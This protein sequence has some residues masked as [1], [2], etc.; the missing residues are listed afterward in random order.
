M[1][2]WIWTATLTMAAPAPND[3][4]PPPKQSTV[5]SVYDGDTVTLA[6]GD[7]IRLRWINTPEL[8]PPE[9]YGIEARS[10][11]EGFVKGE[12]VRL[13]MDGENPRD[14]YG[15][16]LAGLETDRGN[17]TIHLL[18]LGLGHV[19]VI[20]PDD[21]DLAPLLAAQKQA[22]E[23]RRGIWTTDRYQGTLH[24]TSFHANAA[25]DD[26]DN[27]NG[28]YLRICNITGSPLNIE[29]YTITKATGRSWTL[30]RLIIPAG[31]TF[32]L[33]SGLGT[34]Q[35]DAAKQLEVFLGSETPIWNNDFDR[36]TLM[37]PSGNVIDAR[38]HKPK[39][40]GR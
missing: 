24:I 26:R 3:A 32:E 17:L 8:R 37:D 22:Q 27:V 5:E 29:G 4:P 21:T 1:I 10:A 13:L 19:F 16:V 11:A 6:T 34:H 36:A 28:E 30:P 33:H 39:S 25:G 18:E 7:K 20:P 9:P 35:T 14:G 31:H 23:A 12:T 38:E 15:R 40:G 2:A